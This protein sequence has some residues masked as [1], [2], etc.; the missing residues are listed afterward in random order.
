[1]QFEAP[2][3]QVPADTANTHS[4]KKMTHLRA[5]WSLWQLQPS[6]RT[7]KL[8]QKVITSTL[9]HIQMEIL[10]GTGEFLS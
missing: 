3:N 6:L 10:F 2:K 5:E 1:M 7:A 8:G 4:S 9:H